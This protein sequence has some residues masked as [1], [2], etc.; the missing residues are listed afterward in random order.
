[1]RINPQVMEIYFTYFESLAR[2]EEFIDYK[3]GN[4]LIP[5]QLNTKPQERKSNLYCA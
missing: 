2:K 3:I 5:F 1:M 4:N